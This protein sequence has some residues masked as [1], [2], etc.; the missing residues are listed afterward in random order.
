MIDLLYWRRFDNA[1]SLDI[2][3]FNYKL[4]H[5]Q[6]PILS[7]KDIRKDLDSFFSAPDRSPPNVTVR[8]IIVSFEEICNNGTVQD[9][10]QFRN[11]QLVLLL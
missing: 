7:F 10:E 2:F 4:H 9:S 1:S 6:I 11:R 3:A 5:A 8:L